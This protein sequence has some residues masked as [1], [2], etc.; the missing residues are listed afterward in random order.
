MEQKLF[1][2]ILTFDWPKEPVTMYFSDTGYH[3]CHELYFTLFPNEIEQIFPNLARNSTNKLYTTFGYPAED[4]IPLASDLQKENP[5]LVKRFYDD[6]INYY[7]RKKAKQIVK[8]GFI[9]ENQ[10]WIKHANAGT[11]TYHVYH[12]FSLRVQIAQVS[13][14]PEIIVSYDGTSKVCKQPVAEL[15]KTI[16]PTAFNWVLFENRLYKWAKYCELDNTNDEACYPVINKNL[17]APLGIPYVLPDRENNYPKYI[18]LI[19]GFVSRYMDNEQFRKFIP[20]H[21]KE[22]LSV[23]PTRI[24]YTSPESNELLFANNASHTTPKLALGRL[25]P[26]KK[27][28][29][30]NIHLFFILHE[31][32]VSKAKTVMER[33]QKG[34]GFFKGLQDYV[35]LTFYTEE[36]F[37]IKF[38]DKENP[39]AEIEKKLN[40]RAF[41]PDV[42]YIAIYIT[43]YNKFEKDKPKREIYHQL[44]ELLLKRKITSQVID[45]EKMQQQGQS[46]V[47]S[48][49]NIAVAM[50]AKLN[51]IPWQLN[52]PIK[53]EL[54]VGVGAFKH[55][56]T[57]VQY[58]GSAFSFANNGKFNRFEYF[59]KDEIDVLAGSIAHAVK[60]YATVNEDP[61]RL[62]IHFY[63]TMSDD[64]LQPI[65]LALTDLGLSIPVFIITINKTLSEN[66]IAFDSSWKEMMPLSGTFIKIGKQKYLLFNNTRYNGTIHSNADGYPFPLKLKFACTQPEQLNDMKVVRELIDQVYQFSRM[67]WKSIRQQNLP[68]TIKY[69]EMVAQ[70]AP[71]F[72]GNTIP[73]YGKDNLWF[74]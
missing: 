68:V 3:R 26:F 57:N 61:D 63:K 42:K 14:Y 32:D 23:A 10:V 37:S 45:P 51:G 7:F 41:N 15:V 5:D 58:I 46:W 56:E 31:D 6:T 49:P 25:K 62:I 36:N 55:Q 21:S 74:L 18:K 52:T 19:K 17:D 50:M 39:I 11:Q 28:P 53:N 20:I 9:K 54:I 2:N 44:K 40:Q 71:H 1:F 33:F 29:F 27:S 38:S 22:F 4:F 43:P 70:I 66:I 59:L 47:Y 65:E 13:T 8:Q 48:L 72:K 16:S 34:M 69:P 64:E 35:G 12:K 67:Y 24:D 73:P 30:P 60:Q